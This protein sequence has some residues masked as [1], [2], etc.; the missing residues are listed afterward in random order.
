MKQTMSVIQAFKK[1]GQAKK[2]RERKEKKKKKE[3]ELC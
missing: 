2:G 1:T 3:I